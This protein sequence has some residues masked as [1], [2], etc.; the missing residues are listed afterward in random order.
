MIFYSCYR[1]FYVQYNFSKLPS[2]LE[3]NGLGAD[4]DKIA[5]ALVGLICAQK[6]VFSYFEL[7][8]KISSVGF[9]R[10]YFKIPFSGGRVCRDKQEG[11]KIVQNVAKMV[12]GDHSSHRKEID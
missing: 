4:K 8:P 3:R 10:M 9:Q 1:C 2:R 6:D 5:C 12:S 11:A 7:D